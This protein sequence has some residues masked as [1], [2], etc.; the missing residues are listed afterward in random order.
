MQRGACASYAEIG[1]A[2]SSKSLDVAP[3]RRQ[4]LKLR[5]ARILDAHGNP[6]EKSGMLAFGREPNPDADNGTHI[7]TFLDVTLK[8][9]VGT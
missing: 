9:G 1:A 3:T 7:G 6:T 2:Q 8:I 5:S 4:V